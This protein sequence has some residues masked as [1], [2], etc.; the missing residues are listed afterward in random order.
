MIG[1]ELTRIRAAALAATCALL[2]CAPAQ[3]QIWRCENPDGIVEYSNT[4]PDRDRKDCRQVELPSLTTIPAPPAA[5]ST[6]TPRAQPRQEFPR[7]DSSTQ[8]ARDEERRQILKRELGK[9]EERLAALEAEYKDGEPDRLG[10]ERNYQ[11]YLDRVERLKVDITRAEANV[12]SIRR[13][14]DALPR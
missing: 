10:S 11:K 2:W 6:P 3:A 5:T 12:A 8:R 14:I 13:E 1:F 7:V 9:A 4:R